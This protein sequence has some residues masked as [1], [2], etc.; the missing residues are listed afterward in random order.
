M[1]SL[2]E[3]LRVLGHRYQ[4][5]YFKKEV[6]LLLGRENI[7]FSDQALDLTDDVTSML[8]VALKDQNSDN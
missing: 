7:L 2:Q 8:D 3:G 5:T 4:K 6:K 1:R